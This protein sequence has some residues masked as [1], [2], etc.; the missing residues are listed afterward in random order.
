MAKT[1]SQEALYRRMKTAVAQDEPGK[2]G[3]LDKIL[4]T[5][6]GDYRI[7]KQFLE[8][9]SSHNPWKASSQ[10]V[11]KQAVFRTPTEMRTEGEIYGV[12][13][14]G[15]KLT[16]QIFVLTHTYDPTRVWR[17]GSR[18]ITKILEAFGTEEQKEPFTSKGKERIEHRKK[19]QAEICL[20]EVVQTLEDVLKNPDLIDN[21]QSRNDR[22]KVHHILEL[23]E[24][25]KRR[26][27]QLDKVV[28]GNT[29]LMDTDTS[30]HLLA[31]DKGGM[32]MGWFERQKET[33]PKAI[34]DIYTT[35]VNPMISI[36]EEER[37]FMF[38]SLIAYAAGHMYVKKEAIVGNYIQDLDFIMKELPEEHP[39]VKQYGKPDLTAIRHLLP[40]N[41]IT[42]LEATTIFDIYPVDEVRRG[43][44]QHY[45]YKFQKEI[46]PLIEK[47]TPLFIRGGKWREDCYEDS[48][49][50]GRLK[51][52]VYAAALCGEDFHAVRDWLRLK[53]LTQNHET[54]FYQAQSLKEFIQHVDSLIIASRKLVSLEQT[55][56]DNKIEI[57][58]P[59]NIE[60][61]KLP[62]ILLHGKDYSTAERFASGEGITLTEFV[63]RCD[64]GEK[65]SKE[66]KKL[67]GK[68]AEAQRAGLYSE[69]VIKDLRPL[70]DRVKQYIPYKQKQVE[71]ETATNFVEANE[72]RGRAL[73]HHIG[74][75]GLPKLTQPYLTPEECERVNKIISAKAELEQ[76][77]QTVPNLVELLERRKELRGT[78]V[79]HLDKSTGEIN[80]RFYDTREEPRIKLQEIEFT[81]PLDLEQHLN[82]FTA[83][84]VLLASL[85]QKWWSKFDYLISRDFYG[86]FSHGGT[87]LQKEANHCR[88]SWPTYLHS[89]LVQEV[90]KRYEKRNKSLKWSNKV[91]ASGA[92]EFSAGE[93]WEKYQVTLTGGTEE[94]RKIFKNYGLGIYEK[95]DFRTMHKEDVADLTKK[96]AEYNTQA[97]THMKLELSKV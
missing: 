65:Y 41:E 2:V 68:V 74:M 61:I 97:K 45:F 79:Y 95:K 14:S 91:I 76:L 18:A 52:S 80:S 92:E 59:E 5:Y 73:L 66:W 81:N 64:Y 28:Y 89:E 43:I 93:L 24:E 85:S 57:E 17:S 83:N 33:L 56:R 29:A 67:R 32:L 23:D 13:V 34:R 42:L 12:S 4:S 22:L 44:N 60:E 36:P 82:A 87:V 77:E 86:N 27:L 16:D 21:V 1:L 70:L 38:G 15:H 39:I 8:L 51:S 6:T 49:P 35:I 78:L 3:E 84:A 19:A 7:L 96:L 94:Q 30:T 50:L 62:K 58:D 47:L 71:V 25:L 55:L 20:K 11:L 10:A 37:K 40:K 46:E 54:R 90:E 63:K 48:V 69:K 9:F 72:S 26:L 53:T 31:L 88:G 75:W